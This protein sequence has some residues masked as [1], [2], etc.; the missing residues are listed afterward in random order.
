MGMQGKD[1]DSSLAL[2]IHTSYLKMVYHPVNA[3][4]LEASAVLG[5]EF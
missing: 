5:L 3:L 2:S 4:S 1:S